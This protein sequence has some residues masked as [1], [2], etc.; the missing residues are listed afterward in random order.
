M[1]G[2][3]KLR[4]RLNLLFQSLGPLNEGLC[5]PN[6]LTQFSDNLGTIAVVRTIPMMLFAHF[7]TLF[8]DSNNIAQQRGE[9]YLQV[10]YRIFKYLKGLPIN[11]VD[12]V[13]CQWREILFFCADFGGDYE[14]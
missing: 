6:M 7:V 3:Y 10:N 13:V 1:Q 14:V 9:N 2:T 5:F 8:A 12:I 4:S 11:E